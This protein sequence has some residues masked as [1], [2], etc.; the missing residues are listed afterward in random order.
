[1]SPSVEIEEIAKTLAAMPTVD[2]TCKQLQF[3]LKP[4]ALPLKRTAAIQ[5]REHPTAELP[6]VDQKQLH[7]DP[8]PEVAPPLKGKLQVS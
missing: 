3:D 7:L 6:K 1:M 8:K 4:E 2:P 5:E